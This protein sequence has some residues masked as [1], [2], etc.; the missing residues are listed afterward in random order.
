MRT[1]FPILTF[2][3]VMIL[4]A[5]S[6]TATPVPVPAVDQTVGPSI[7]GQAIDTPQE[8]VSRWCTLLQACRSVTPI[9]DVNAATPA[10]DPAQETVG[11]VTFPGVCIPPEGSPADDGFHL[12]C[13]GEF[14]VAGPATLGPTPGFASIPLQVVTPDLA[15]I[16][17]YV[18][19][20]AQGHHT[21]CD[22]TTT[23]GSEHV[24]DAPPVTVTARLVVPAGSFLDPHAGEFYTIPRTDGT[25]DLP[26]GQSI[27]YWYCEPSCSV[28]RSPEGQLA[29]WIDLTIEAGPV[30]HTEHIPLGPTS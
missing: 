4:A 11:P 15:S 23:V 30:S 14:E 5:P 19:W 28:P 9:P 3:A 29:A 20:A 8:S 26:T 24:G 13:I 18:N 1:T 21:G 12:L 16:C 6:V 7:P 10:V 27:P 25:L 22:T 17:G 2:L